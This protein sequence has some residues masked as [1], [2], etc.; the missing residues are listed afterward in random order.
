MD[1]P[2]L[3][4]AKKEKKNAEK[5]LNYHTVKELLYK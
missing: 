5:E 4:L 3:R 2:N 1:E